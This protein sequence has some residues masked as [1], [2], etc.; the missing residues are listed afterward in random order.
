LHR[1]NNA[2]LPCYSLSNVLPVCC[3]ENTSPLSALQ[4]RVQMPT[5]YFFLLL[6]LLL[7]QLPSARFAAASVSINAES[8]DSWF[9]RDCSDSA[10]VAFRGG[11]QV[12]LLVVAAAVSNTDLRF[13]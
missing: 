5:I 13:A 6:S 9:A 2:V 11:V 3:A 10:P 12:G 4:R 1:F 8:E 7:I